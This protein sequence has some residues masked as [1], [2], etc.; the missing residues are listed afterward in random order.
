MDTT[1]LPVEA[2]PDF[3]AER[4]ET[5]PE[6]GLSII[7]GALPPEQAKTLESELKEIMD[8]VEREPNDGEAAKNSHS[9]VNQVRYATDL[10]VGSGFTAIT[11]VLEKLHAA[12]GYQAVINHQ[13]PAGVQK[14]HADDN[15]QVEV[16]ENNPLFVIQGSDGGYLDYSPGTSLF[17]SDEI[18]EKNA[19]SVPV[20]AGDIVVMT[21]PM[22]I[23]R[24]RNATNHDRYN[25][26]V[27]SERRPLSL[28]EAIKESQAQAWE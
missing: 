24:G 10:I 16:S 25:L 28:E 6:A 27:F 17:D 19:V 3:Q 8:G 1:S 14:F 7:R 9:N 11:G 12:H 5:I 13:K 4:V 23:H 2:S 22:L 15:A 26:V 20:N 18:A 21:N